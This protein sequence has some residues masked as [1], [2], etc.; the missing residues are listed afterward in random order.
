MSPNDAA[1]LAA[2]FTTPG[3]NAA[4][5]F[6]IANVHL[7]D[8][9]GQCGR[10]SSWP[11]GKF[12]TFFGDGGASPVGD[13]DRLSRPTPAYQHDP[14][15][16]GTDAASGAG[17]AGRRTWP[18]SSPPFCTPGATRIFVTERDIRQRP[19]RVRGSA[20]RA[21]HRQR[22][23]RSGPG[24]RKA[25]LLGVHATGSPTVPAPPAAIVVPPPVA[26]DAAAT[27][28]R[29]HPQSRATQ[30]NHST[31]RRLA[32]KPAP[33]SDARPWRPRRPSL[34]NAEA[35]AQAEAETATPTA[36]AQA[37]LAPCA[38]SRAPRGIPRRR[39][40]HRSRA[41]GADPA[42]AHPPAL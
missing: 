38:S 4:H 29:P 25:G 31:T 42:V 3:S 12:F 6:D 32:A 19:I 28:R 41:R 16:R 14:G 18:R 11:G 30:P 8:T 33:P 20:R 2:V 24:V 21:R 39:A 13:R 37:A 7:R 5:A 26:T 1:W 22:R 17:R 9:R 40:K 15:F 34:A 10:P 23:D 36:E 35:Q 27:R